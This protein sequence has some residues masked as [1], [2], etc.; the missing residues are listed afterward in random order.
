MMALCAFVRIAA[1]LLFEGDMV[2]TSLRG[3]GQAEPAR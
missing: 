2:G 3:R 1:V